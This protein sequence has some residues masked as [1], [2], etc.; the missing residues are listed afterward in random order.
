MIIDV[1]VKFVTKIIRLEG[2]LDF[3]LGV[4]FL[5]GLKLKLSFRCTS[6]EEKI[7]ASKRNE[8]FQ[9]NL[10]QNKGERL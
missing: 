3:D 5:S 8:I 6:L 9:W 7:I 4:E 1:L 2:D 10:K